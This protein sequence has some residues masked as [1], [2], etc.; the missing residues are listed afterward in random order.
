[1]RKMY[2][3]DEILTDFI[4]QTRSEGGNNDENITRLVEEV[5]PTYH[6]SLAC[7]G[8]KDDTYKKHG[9]N[10]VSYLGEIY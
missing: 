9:K 6:P 10:C 5:V 4:K 7:A 3:Q 1:M 8:K 2:I